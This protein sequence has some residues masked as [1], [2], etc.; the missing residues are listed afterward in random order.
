MT[1]VTVGRRF[2][3]HVNS[4]QSDESQ[5]RRIFFYP[6]CLLRLTPPIRLYRLGQ[7]RQCSNFFNSP[8]RKRYLKNIQK[9][10]SDNRK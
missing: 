3:I 2:C 4:A 1:T 10:T 8:S 7:S 9:K 6:Q 5:V